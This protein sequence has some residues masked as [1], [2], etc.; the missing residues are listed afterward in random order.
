M[1][2]ET[3][4]KPRQSLAPKRESAPRP[5]PPP[6]APAPQG[7]AFRAELDLAE[8]DDRRRPG[9]PWV[10]RGYELSRSHL[11]FRSRKMCYEGRLLLVLVHL[12]DDRPAFLFGQVRHCEYDSDGQYRTCLELLPVP[13]EPEIQAWIKERDARGV[14]P[15]GPGS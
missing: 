13:L 11:T 8:L 10:G 15:A 5:A 1:R 7:S 6:P 12:V 9:G 14:V 2:L 3:V 4:Q